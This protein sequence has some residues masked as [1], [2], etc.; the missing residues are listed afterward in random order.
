MKIVEDKNPCDRT[1]LFQVILGPLLA[2]V[3]LCVG[4][5]I[6]AKILGRKVPPVR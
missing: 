2:V 5:V 4:V 3:G 6:P 1:A